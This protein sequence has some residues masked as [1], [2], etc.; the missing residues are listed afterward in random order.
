MMSHEDGHH[1][2]KSI[3]LKI[4]IVSGKNHLAILKKDINVRPEVGDEKI[5]NI[6]RYK[7][8]K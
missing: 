8:R 7:F 2:P 3:A 6:K 1:H 4:R 5:I